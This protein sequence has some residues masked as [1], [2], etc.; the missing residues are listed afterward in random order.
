MNDENEINQHSVSM[1]AGKK[2]HDKSNQMFY[3]TSVRA[4]T[5]LL[6]FPSRRVKCI[7][8]YFYRGASV[9]GAIP[10]I[11]VFGG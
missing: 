8:G 4:I 5:E 3:L 1:Q 2:N 9:L 10:G 6:I 11:I 7:Q